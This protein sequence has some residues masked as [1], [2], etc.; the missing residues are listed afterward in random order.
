ME[1]FEGSNWIAKEKSAYIDP[2]DIL[3]SLKE[4]GQQ[5]N[6]QQGTVVFRKA[7]TSI[8]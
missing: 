5:V 8:S 3:N 2:N 4:N 7:F 6:V 1:S